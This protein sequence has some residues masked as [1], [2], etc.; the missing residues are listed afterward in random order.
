MVPYSRQ[1]CRHS[2]RVQLCAVAGR[3]VHITNAAHV[4]CFF[5]M[6]MHHGH[7]GEH[8]VLFAHMLVWCM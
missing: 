8:A 3:A 1:S 4:P 2:N 5:L 7:D 6:R